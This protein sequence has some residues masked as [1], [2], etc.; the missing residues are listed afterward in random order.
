MGRI[1]GIVCSPRNGGNTEILVHKALLSTEESN[2]ESD[3]ITLA[4][5]RIFPC[6]GCA[7]CRD[8]NECRIQDDMQEIYPKMLSADGLLVASPVYFWN[9]SGLA[10][11][12]VD[13]TYAFLHKR[14]LRNKIGGI[15]VVAG[16]AGCSNA[17]LALN[18]F[19]TIHRMRVAG[20]V[21]AYG[22]EKGSVLTDVQSMK[23]AGK[24]GNVIARLIRGKIAEEE[25]KPLQ[26]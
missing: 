3:I 19:F 22:S 1:L 11:I 26:H 9:I 25:E 14:R 17:W 13:R 18:S 12:F 5:K 6:D 2:I 23:E 4:N 20:G 8:T 10:K 21:I 15:I 7:R 16:R 24:L